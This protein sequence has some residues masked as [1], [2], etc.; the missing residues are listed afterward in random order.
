MAE[1]G[2]ASFTS[3]VDISSGTYGGSTTTDTIY[4]PVI[5]K[6]ETAD[7]IFKLTVPY[8]KV[9]GPGNMTPNIG[10]AVYANNAVRTDAGLGDV[11]AGATYSLVNSGRTGTV[12]DIAGKVKFGT[13]DKYKGLGTGANDYSGELSL[14]KIVGNRSVFGS[15]GY[16]VFGQSAGYTLNNALYGS[17]G[18]SNKV[19]ARNSIGLI[20]DYREATSSWSDPQQMWTAFWNAKIGSNW[21][22]QSYLFKG[23]GMSSPDMGGGIMV[24]EVF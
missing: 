23:I 9:T 3:G 2:K 22:V 21:K 11:V 7:W 1:Q 13:A 4:I 20:Y 8:I 16:K 10:Q 24:T 12:I 18:V 14:Y 17:V 15:A 5:A 19:G 6:Y